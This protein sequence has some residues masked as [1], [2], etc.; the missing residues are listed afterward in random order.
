MARTVKEYIERA[1]RSFF[2]KDVALLQFSTIAITGLSFISSVI[3]AR[4]L[5]PEKYGV[6]AIIFS[7]TA[8]LGSFADWSGANYVVTTFLSR[9]YVEKNREQIEN[10][11]GYVA[12]MFIFVFLPLTALAIVIAPYLSTNLY[13]SSYIGIMT[14]L[15]LFENILGAVFGILKVMLEATRKIKKLTVLEIIEKIFFIVIPILFVL[16]SYGI[17]G[18]VWGTIVASVIMCCIGYVLYRKLMRGDQLFPSMRTVYSRSIERSSGHY[19]AFGFNASLD[20]T[21]SNISSTLPVVFLAAAVTHSEV[22]FYKLA[23]SYTS[24]SILLLKPVA[25]LLNSQLPKSLSYGISFLKRDFY[26]ATIIS[27]ALACLAVLPFI[28]LAGPL[29]SIF[30]GA[31]FA[32]VVQLVPALMLYAIIA[33]V[34]TG[35][36]ALFRTIQKVRVAVIINIVNFCVSTPI[37]YFIIMQYGV[38]GMIWSSIADSLAIAI[39]CHIYFMKYFDSVIKQPMNAS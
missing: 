3:L 16:L 33:A 11:V 32:P 27:T 1:K 37:I 12:K 17:T 13:H 28:I 29:V 24:L 36:G 22:G 15:L 26:R 20:K 2:F 21:L 14:R 30:Y 10:I 18:Y 6:Y 19:I 31:A 9:A 7:F 23:L 5:G 35:I 34:S 38:G 25:R 39:V 4:I 8:L